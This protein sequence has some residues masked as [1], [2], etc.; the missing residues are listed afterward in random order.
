MLDFCTIV[1]SQNGSLVTINRE[2]VAWRAEAEEKLTD[3]QGDLETADYQIA[4]LQDGEKEH[5][6]NINKLEKRVKVLEEKQKE[7]QKKNKDL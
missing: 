3:A 6:D 1:D 5:L 7:L 2:E 4:L